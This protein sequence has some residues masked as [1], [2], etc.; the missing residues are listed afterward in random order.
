MRKMSQN[1]TA[2]ILQTNFKEDACS[3]ISNDKSFI[4]MNHVEKSPAFW[5]RFQ[6]KV[7]AMIS[8]HDCP[9]FFLNLSCADLQWR[10]IFSM[11]FKMNNKTP[12]K[13]IIG[14]R[15]YYEH[16]EMLNKHPLFAAR[17]FH[18][19]VELFFTAV[20]PVHREILCKIQHSAHFHSFFGLASARSC[21]VSVVGKN[22]LVTQFSQK[23][24]KGFFWF[25]ALS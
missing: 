21:K 4:F 23:Q 13:E 2:G 3:L 10:D 7:L 8:Q 15:S 12:S 20:L 22:W 9:T 24:L 6:L 25:F 5:K 14:N 19:R 11:I 17:H 1:L 16:C 18:C